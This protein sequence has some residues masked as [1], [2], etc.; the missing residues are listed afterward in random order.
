MLNKEPISIMGAGSWGTTLAILL[1]SKTGPRVT[2][3]SAFM[4]H[5]QKMYKERENTDFL[6]GFK[7]TEELEVSSS[8][9]NALQSKVIIIAVPVQYMRS[10]LKRIKELDI[11]LSNKL[12]VSVSKGIELISLK[13][14][15]ELI[16]E[17]LEVDKENIAVLSGPT[18]ALEIAAG[19]PAVATVSCSNEENAKFIQKYFNGKNLRV[20]TNTDIVGVELAGALKNIIAIAC[21]ISDGLGFGTNTKSALVSRGLK[22]MIAFS[23]LQNVKEETFWGVSGLGDLCTTCFS[24]DSRNRTLG[25]QIGKGANLENILSEMKMVAEGV[26]TAKSV[27]SIA[28]EHAIDMPIASEVYKVLYEDK[29]PAAAVTDLMSRPLKSE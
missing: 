19:K 15:Y 28:S 4:V 22:E 3:W 25:E 6:P 9:I 17:V 21:G 18:I 27:Y 16:H 1:S 11:D 14:P 10:V 8:L 5:L 12:F 29:T 26:V 2:L 20:Y 7:F 24:A 13:T 23:K